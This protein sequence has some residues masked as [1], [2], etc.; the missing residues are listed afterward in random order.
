MAC[1]ALEVVVTRLDVGPDVAR[2]VVPLLSNVERER[3]R[4]FA[5]ERDRH[6]FVIARGR[7]RQLLGG[8]LNVAPDSVQLVYGPRGKPAL[9]RAF[10]GSGLRFNVSR[11]GEVAVYAFAYDREIGVDVEEVRVL[12][13]ADAIAAQMFSPRE[14]AAYFALSPRHRPLG[15]FH[16]WTRKEAFVKAL[17]DGLYYPLDR[18]D[19]SLAPGEPARILRVES[20]AGDDCPWTLHTFSPGA[21]LAGA[22]VVQKRAQES[23][24]TAAPESLVVRW[25]PRGY[26]TG[27]MDEHSAA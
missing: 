15:F 8:R 2:A 22:V 17:G 9:A 12:P 23:M 14:S 24:A 26:F 16:C 4:R 3:A 20:T 13:D 7:L 25:L 10:A 11:S 19:V 1:D 27:T 5:F 21:G 6:R 18:F